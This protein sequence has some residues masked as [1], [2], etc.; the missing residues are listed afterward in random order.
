MLIQLS[1]NIMKNR[2]AFFS[3]FFLTVFLMS[4]ENEGE[5]N[6]VEQKNVEQSSTVENAERLGETFTLMTYSSLEEL[7]DKLPDAIASIIDDAQD[8]IAND[9]RITDAFINLRFSDGKAY[10]GEV[11]FYNQ[12]NEEIVSGQILDFNTLFYEQISSTTTFPDFSGLVGSCPTGY[13]SV[14][15]CDTLSSKVKS[16]VTE[17]VATFMSNSLND[18]GDCANV[19]VSIGAFVTRICGKTC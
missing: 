11:V 2:I 8:I 5:E 19:Q 10:I 15:T 4:C 14:G 13:T 7:Q 1:I 17:K 6:L 3:L 16:C 12:D 18:I 9:E